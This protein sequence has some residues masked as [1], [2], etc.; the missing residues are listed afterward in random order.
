MDPAIQ[1][2]IDR[3]YA[4]AAAP[5]EWRPALEGVVDLLHGRHATL[6]V[7][8]AEPVRAAFVANAR[9]DERDLAA[10]LSAEA[11][12][13]AA[14]L[15]AATPLGVST[16]DAII[17]DADFERSALYNELV[18]PLHGFHSLQFRR[19]GD[20][21]GFLLCVCRPQR[22]GN[23]EVADMAALRILGPHLAT[24][25]ALQ[26]R[27]QAAEQGQARLAGV[28]DR[29]AAGVI[30]ADA[31]ARAT[32]V[33]AP[34]SAIIAER[35]GLLLDADRLAA[36][37]PAAT[38]ELRDAIAAVAADAI[39][40]GR[41]LRL[42]R[43][44][45]RPPLVLTVLPIWR[46]GAILPGGGPAARVAVFIKDLGAPLGVDRLAVAEAFRLTPRECEVAVL[47]ADGHDLA[48]IAAMLGVGLSTVRYHLKRVF[49]K[50]GMRSQAALAVLIRGFADPWH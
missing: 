15:I 31:A 42:E 20:G 4:A 21:G 27:L 22:A 32:F 36:A 49:E 6:D 41:R 16:R 2:T 13:M 24:A 47:L 43:P 23:F 46:L 34:G 19:N 48:R 37:T 39:T 8:N 30:V 25:L 28:L 11:M 44:S 35:D 17:S 45:Q 10:L 14:P 26:S 5:G 50:T 29:L 18:R 40:E 12:R 9:V 38:Q 7:R 3:I 1:Q 33:N